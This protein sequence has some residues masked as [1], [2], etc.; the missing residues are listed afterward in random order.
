MSSASEDLMLLDSSPVPQGTEMDMDSP[1][2]AAQVHLSNARVQFNANWTSSSQVAPEADVVPFVFQAP[3]DEARRAPAVDRRAREA[4]LAARAGSPTSGS[5]QRLSPAGR[6]ARRALQEGGSPGLPSAGRSRRRQR[7]TAGQDEEMVARNSIPMHIISLA[8]WIAG[9]AAVAVTTLFRLFSA[10]ATEQQAQVIA[11]PLSSG[12]RRCVLQQTRR[13]VPYGQY[14]EGSGSVEEWRRKE[15]LRLARELEEER[16][17]QQDVAQR[18]RDNVAGRAGNTLALRTPIKKSAPRWYMRQRP[19]AAQL[20][21]AARPPLRKLRNRRFKLAAASGLPVVREWT[22]EPESPPRLARGTEQQASQAVRQTTTTVE[23]LHLPGSFEVPQQLRSEVTPR[24]TRS[25]LKGYS[26]LTAP[27]ATRTKLATNGT[28]SLKPHL[29]HAISKHSK[30]PVPATTSSEGAT[31]RRIPAKYFSSTKRS[32]SELNKKREAIIAEI[33][34]IERAIDD[35]PHTDASPEPLLRRVSSQRSSSPQPLL[36]RVSSQQSSS[37]Q[38]LLTIVSS[39][40]SSTPQTLLTQASS[41]ISSE[42]T[43]EPDSIRSE[44]ATTKLPSNHASAPI[45]LERLSNSVGSNFTEEPD[46]ESSNVALSQQEHSAEL[47]SATALEPPLSNASSDHHTSSKHAPTRRHRFFAP[48]PLKLDAMTMGRWGVAA[49]A[50]RTNDQILKDENIDLL[51][52]K[53][54]ALQLLTEE[55]TRQRQQLLDDFARAKDARESRKEQARREAQA[56]VDER[57]ARLEHFR[58]EALVKKQEAQQEA[59]ERREREEARILALEQAEALEQARQKA[60]TEAAARQIFSKGGLIVEPSAAMLEALNTKM[61]V[62]QDS[63]V[64]ATTVTNTT[65][66]RAD[67]A[68]VLGTA[69]NGRAPAWLNDVS[70]NAWLSVLCAALNEK[71]GHVKARNGPTP[72]FA[73]YSSAW[74]KQCQD[75]GAASLKRWTSRLGI[76]DGRLDQADM[77]FLPVNTGAHWTLAIIHGKDKTIEYLDSLGGA[78]TAVITAVRSLLASEL[79]KDYREDEWTISRSR[80]SSQDNS[81]DCGV[82]TCFNAFAAARNIAFTQVT[83]AKMPIARRLMAAVL[84]NGGFTGDAKL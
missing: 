36:T 78:G 43:E 17:L 1:R 37:P 38:P 3:A 23:D 73:A 8:S 68:R 11:V 57:N 62:R 20:K 45:P 25:S 54:R 52:K 26:H 13:T 2:F 50:A 55:E 28:I 32:I 80:S 7:G 83:A 49:V 9:A 63:A 65:I 5:P 40:Q 6:L 60:Q 31:T 81:D 64:I 29:T 66:E 39:Q 48:P 51:T 12:K 21:T 71:R 79:G 16:E 77:I 53:A 84:M 35:S 74:L 18:I 58:Q 27:K 42:T 24:P 76:K 69:T 67:M 61:A 4:H 14:L 75:K 15:A 46:L 22:P 34:A 33:A 59:A 19:T 30:K 72:P 44:A 82:F 56:R 47:S 41:K 10:S 70:V